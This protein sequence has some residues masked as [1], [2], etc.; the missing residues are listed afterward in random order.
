MAQKNSH[1]KQSEEEEK[2]KIKISGGS[3]RLLKLTIPSKINFKVPIIDD[4]PYTNGILHKIRKI[5]LKTL[6]MA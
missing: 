3:L 6:K 4:R 2:G 1:K 5:F